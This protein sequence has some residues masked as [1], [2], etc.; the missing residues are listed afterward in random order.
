MDLAQGRTPFEGNALSAVAYSWALALEDIPT[1]H[2]AECFK[3]AL[4]AKRDDFP[5][6]APAVNKAYDDY[7]ID[8][9]KQAAEHAEAQERLLIAGHG[10]L[11]RMTVDEWKQRH[12]LPMEWNP[13]EGKALV[14]PPESDLYNKPLPTLPE[15]VI[16]CRRCKD[17]WWLR[18]PFDPIRLWAAKLMPCSCQQKGGTQ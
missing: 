4:K 10:S 3:R 16:R 14:I 13:F 2:L 9:I 12:N 11:D 7:K 17:A 15:D 18:I 8:L 5:I 6:S 1:H